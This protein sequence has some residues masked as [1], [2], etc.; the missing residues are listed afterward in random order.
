[1]VLDGLVVEGDLVHGVVEP[2]LSGDGAPVAGR[3]LFGVL[4]ELQ[5]VDVRC[6]LAD[7]VSEVGQGWSGRPRSWPA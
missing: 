7:D 6:R 4:A 3:E 2:A 1:V 5:D